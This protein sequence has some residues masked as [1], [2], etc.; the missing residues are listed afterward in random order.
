MTHLYTT[1][2]NKHRNKVIELWL[3]GKITFEG[4]T[5]HLAIAKG[6]RTK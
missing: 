4:I 5:C 6:E 3:D 2:H 1:E